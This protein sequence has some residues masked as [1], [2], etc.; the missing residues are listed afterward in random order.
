MMIFTKGSNNR[1]F[2]SSPNMPHEIKK[3]L[4]NKRETFCS[5]GCHTSFYLK[6]CLV[7]EGPLERK[8]KTQRVC[9]KSQC[10]NAWKAGFGRYVPSAV[11]NSAS[12]TPNSIGSKW[13]PR[14]DRAW[15]QIAGPKL[16]ASQLHCGLVGAVQAVAETDQKNRPHWRRHTAK[17]LLQPHDPPVNIP[18]GYRFPGA[19]NVK[20]RE[21]K[22][23][24]SS[25]TAVS[26]PDA[27]LDIPDSLKRR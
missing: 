13:A 16:T 10:R 26:K 23:P 27:N 19:P 24:R 14:Q 4:S 8:N 20:L 12:K 17:A 21:E 9:G 5:R 22:N 25:L 7:C 11:V 15:D 3:P 6:R 1:D 2:L 18:G